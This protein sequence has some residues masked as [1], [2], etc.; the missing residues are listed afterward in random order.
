ML[1]RYSA[2]VKRPD[3]GYEGRVWFFREVTERKAA[4]HALRRLNRTLRTLSRANEA[5]VHAASEAG[6]L[7]E[8]CQVM[9]DTGGYRMAWVG[10]PEQD[11]AE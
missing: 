6:L 10:V 8:M 4:E 11:D 1:D 3:G 2:P 5:L 7:S 9:V